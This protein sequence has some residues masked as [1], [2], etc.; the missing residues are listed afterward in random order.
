M[1]TGSSGYLGNQVLIALKAQEITVIE[2]D[3]YNLTNPVD[4][5]DLRLLDKLVLPREYFLVHLAFPLPGAY[6]SAEFQ[7]LIRQINT[8]IA[9]VFSPSRTLFISSTAVYPIHSKS[10]SMPKPWEIYGELKYETEVFFKDNFSNLTVFRPGT[11]VESTRASTMMTFVKQLMHSKIVLLPGDGEMIHPF[12]HT[13]DLIN[14]II[15]WVTDIKVP[16]GTFDLTAREPLTY[17]QLSALGH[18]NSWFLKVKL[19]E[20]FMSRIGSDRLPIR[21]I[22]KWHFRALYY[23]Y[24]QPEINVFQTKYRSYSEIF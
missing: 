6:K 14:S 17:N 19:P 24:Q 5:A 21:N 7:S 13:S 9:G 23:N 8:N 11:L 2:I 18:K 10:Q 15:S 16:E 22:S 4:L 3:K 20:F 12:T 1:L